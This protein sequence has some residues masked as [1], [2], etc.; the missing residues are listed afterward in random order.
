[1][2]NTTD[3]MEYF[4]IYSEQC[5]DCIYFQDINC[6]LNIIDEYS[7]GLYCGNFMKK[8]KELDE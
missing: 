7:K 8:E 5:V 3:E 1:M 6:E 2:I 4:N